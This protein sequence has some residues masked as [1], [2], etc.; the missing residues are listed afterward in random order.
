[1][2]TT[3]ISINDFSFAYLLYIFLCFLIISTILSICGLIILI[4]IWINNCERKVEKIYFTILTIIN[5]TF[6][7]FIY[8]FNLLGFKI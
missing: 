5:F 4:Y 1:M 7:W 6:I 3:M 8:Y 2:A